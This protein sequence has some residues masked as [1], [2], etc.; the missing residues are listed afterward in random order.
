MT[1]NQDTMSRSFDVWGHVVKNSMCLIAVVLSLSGCG[2]NSGNFAEVKGKVLLDGKPLTIGSVITLPK[3]GRGARGTIDSAGEFSLSTADL[4]TGA[5]VGTHHVAVV[6][7]EQPDSAN[8]NP[9]APVRSLIPQ[10]YG[11]AE[12]SGLII[13]VPPQGVSDVVLE[14][15][16]Q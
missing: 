12:T 10:R 5:S 16:T 11:H 2:R 4:G 6:A 14:L 8:F 7:V 13:E 1:G 9:E 15:S 3:Q